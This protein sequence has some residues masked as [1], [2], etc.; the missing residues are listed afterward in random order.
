[1]KGLIA[2]IL[3]LT[4]GVVQAETTFEAGTVYSAKTVSGQV[5]VNCQNRPS[6]LRYCAGYDLEPGMS[7]RLISGAD[8]D[9]FVVEALHENGKSVSKKGKFNASEGRSDSINLWIRTLFQKPLLAMGT[10]L[11]RYTLTKK[12]DVV[13]QGE[14]NVSVESGARQ[15]CQTGTVWSPGNDC[16]S[17]SYVCDMYF[18]R[19]CN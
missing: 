2:L 6:E 7:T 12:G 13:E 14:F 18:D 3:I 17:Q 15:V 10:N 5:W 9:R 11:I 1:M 4:G 19:Y 16:G 8:A